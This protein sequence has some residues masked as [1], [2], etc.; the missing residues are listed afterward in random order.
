[1]SVELTFIRVL[2]GLTLFIA[3]LFVV[4]VFAKQQVKKAKDGGKE[5]SNY[6]TRLKLLSNDDIH[7]YAS[8]SRKEWKNIP[9]PKGFNRA[10]RKYFYAFLKQEMATRQKRGQL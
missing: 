8:L 6:P 1:M 2:I 5:I 3:L 4:T 9:L 10:Y 7:K